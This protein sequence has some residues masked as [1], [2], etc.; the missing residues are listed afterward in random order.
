MILIYSFEYLV[1]ARDT[2]PK[3]NLRAEEAEELS[4]CV[5]QLFVTMMK[6]SG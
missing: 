3:G 4:C 1:Y 6:Y 5:G 2:Q